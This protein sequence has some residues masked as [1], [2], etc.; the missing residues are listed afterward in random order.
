MITLQF[1]FKDMFLAPRLGFSGKKIWLQFVGL[2]LGYVFYLMFTYLALLADGG[3][4]LGSIW[5]SF[6]LYPC[7]F[8][9]GGIGLL[10]TIL[11]AI[12]VIG[13]LVGLLWSALTVAK[14]TYQQLRDDE[15]YPISEASDYAKKKVAHTLLSPVSIGLFVVLILVAGALVG[16]WGMIPF[17][18]EW[19]VALLVIPA[20]F[21]GLFVVLSLIAIV[22]MLV[23][24]P[25]IIAAT[26]GDFFEG[27]LET[28][29]MTIAQPWRLVV[30]QTLVK[31]SVLLAA[32]V[33]YWFTAA[34]L[35]LVK[36]AYGYI[37]SLSDG[38]KFQLIADK[39]ASFLPSCGW[40]CCGGSGGGMNPVAGMSWSWTLAAIIA[41][42]SLFLIFGFVVAYALA[43]LN[44]GHLLVYLNLKQRKDGENLLEREDF[45]AEPE[46]TE[47]EPE[48]EEKDEGEEENKEE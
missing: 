5:D 21:I 48:T 27:V 25:A 4:T 44:V 19:T 30:Y 15:F 31:S 24:S 20:Y 6:G 11:A 35:M 9:V 22:L 38:T 17:I 1:N 41:G 18:G 33:L 7:A 26:D 12:G 39:A 45:D 46:L 40:L 23:Y 29:S 36:W 28:Y 10:P 43:S 34:S 16:L 47:T 8:S 32:L 3:F 42:I 13:L 37:P 14:V 2:F